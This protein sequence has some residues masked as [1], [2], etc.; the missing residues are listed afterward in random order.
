MQLILVRHARPHRA[1]GED[2]TAD[3]ALTEVGLQQAAATA[4]FL[5]GEDVH[6]VVASPL[7]RAH[8]TAEP[9]AGK[10]GL[11]IETVDGLREIDP[12]G[13]AYVPA[14]E[15]TMDHQII[16]DLARDP[17]ALFGSAGGFERFRAVVVDAVDGV[18]ARNR[19]R[20]VAVYCHGTVIGSYL[21]AILGSDDPFVLLPDYCGLYRVAASSTGL[22]TLRSAN[23]TA[24]VRHLL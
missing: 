16:A 2:A 24:H 21:S 1:D 19:G 17:Y 3:P 10:L 15:V 13:G 7:R 11:D 9:L 4:E 23:E 18:V 20:T 6:H 22:R 14:E 5:L 12:F 8:Q